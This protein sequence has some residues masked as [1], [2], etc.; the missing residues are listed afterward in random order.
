MNLLQ[1]AANNQNLSPF[2][3][4]LLKFGQT[5]LWT[6]GLSVLPA[7]SQALN[8]PGAIDWRVTL[9]LMLFSG[10]SALLLGIVKYLKA[11]GDDPLLSAVEGALEA[12]AA[13]LS[14]ANGLN[15]PVTEPD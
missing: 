9:H 1:K 14:A 2:E 13:R 4:G 11:Q 8:N 10:A 3:R 12:G 7:L 5:L 15:E 6:V